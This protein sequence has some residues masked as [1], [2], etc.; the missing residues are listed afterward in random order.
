V[1]NTKYED[2]ILK[3]KYFLKYSSQPLEKPNIFLLQRLQ[4]LVTWKQSNP[5]LPP[6]N[7]TMTATTVNPW[8][9]ILRDKPTERFG[10]Q[11]IHPP[12]MNS[13]VHYCGHKSPL[14]TPV[15][16]HVSPV[17]ILPN[18]FLK[19]HFNITLSFTPR[20]SKWSLHLNFP[21]KILNALLSAM[22]VTIQLSILQLK[23]INQ[24][25]IIVITI[26]KICLKYV[27]VIC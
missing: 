21:I 13:K 5:F 26:L 27:L 25:W 8:S 7:E 18:H 10:K 11:K 22:K 6:P 16:S 2:S 23:L 24:K 3:L 4:A 1:Y 17:H 20:C 14:L 19:L 15:L 9:R 12:Y